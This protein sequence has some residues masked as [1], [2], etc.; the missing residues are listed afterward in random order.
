MYRKPKSKLLSSKCTIYDLY[1]DVGAQISVGRNTLV[2]GLT[3]STS[4]SVNGRR[5]YKHS[6]GS[7]GSRGSPYCYF[8]YSFPLCCTVTFPSL[9]LGY[10]KLH[11]LPVSGIVELYELAQNIYTIPPLENIPAYTC[12][13]PIFP[14]G[15]RR[16]L[17]QIEIGP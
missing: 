6:G 1:I 12:T 8:F 14:L 13:F 3:K 10:F 11:R 7:N 16:T 4:S 17:A 5:G 2:S 9:S 15:S